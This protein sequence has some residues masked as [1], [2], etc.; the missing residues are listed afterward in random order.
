MKRILTAASVFILALS[1]A[2]FLLG[3]EKRLK[4]GTLT[5]TWECTSHGGPHGDMHFTLFLQQTKDDVAGSVT[6]PLGSTELTSASFKNK[7]LEIHIDTEQGKYLLTAKLVKGQLVG[8]W[9]Q[10]MTRKGAWEGKKSAQQAPAG[11]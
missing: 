11:H 6:S 2:S 1:M 7:A 9:S 3:K 10:D 8:E 5:G 4:A